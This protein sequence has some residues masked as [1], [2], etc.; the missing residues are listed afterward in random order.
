MIAQ[1]H[2]TARPTG[3]GTPRLASPAPCPAQPRMPAASLWD[4]GCGRESDPPSPARQPRGCGSAAALAT[5]LPHQPVRPTLASLRPRPGP[6]R[7]NTGQPRGPAQ[8]GP[9]AAWLWQR[10]CPGDSVAAAMRL[11]R[12]CP[13]G[14]G[15]DG[16][17]GRGCWW[18]GGD[19][20]G[21][22]GMLVA[23]RGAGGRAGRWWPGGDAGGRAG[24]A[25]QMAGRGWAGPGSAGP[26]QCGG[27]PVARGDHGVGV[28]PSRRASEPLDRPRHRHRGDDLPAWTADRCGH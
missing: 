17:A 27:D 2:L 10:C 5:V 8:P 16:A 4:R 14:L 15:A 9:R 23:G 21:R 1:D 20:G 24:R 6:V 11:G 25:G 12:E 22:A 13:G 19:A 28:Q 18:P 26:A 3:P 7:P